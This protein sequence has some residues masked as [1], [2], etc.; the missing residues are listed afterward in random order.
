MFLSL[1]DLEQCM[2][3]KV[4]AQYLLGE[5]HEQILKD[6]IRAYNLDMDMNLIYAILSGSRPNKIE[7]LREFIIA[8]A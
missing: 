1:M 2:V 3:D 8:R 5:F 4:K 6:L 7:L